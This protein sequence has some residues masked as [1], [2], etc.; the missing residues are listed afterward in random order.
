MKLKEIIENIDKSEKN[1]CDIDFEKLLSEF[2]IN[3]YFPYIDYKDS[4][5]RSYYI[6]NWQCT[7]QFVG[8]RAYF[9]DDK[10]VCTSWQSAR[11]SSEDFS[12]VSKETYNEVKQ[13]VISLLYNE[14]KEIN[15]IDL[16]EEWNDGFEINYGSQ[17]LTDNVIY[18]PTVEMVKVVKKWWNYTD[19][20]N[21]ENLEIQFQD[22]KKE[23]VSMSDILIPYNLKK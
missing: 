2:D 13:Y 7:D 5:L 23:I 8:G 20:D 21:W 11:K 3:G 9:L 10:L 15:V 16:D 22:G 18:K 17:L 19:I 1:S 6:V 4:K 14:D 12:W